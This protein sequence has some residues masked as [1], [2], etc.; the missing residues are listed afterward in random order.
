VYLHISA[1]G[2][3]FAISGSQLWLLHKCYKI[4]YMKIHVYAV[5]LI[6]QLKSMMLELHAD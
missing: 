2:Q 4:F 1:Q 3:A 6:M 5:L